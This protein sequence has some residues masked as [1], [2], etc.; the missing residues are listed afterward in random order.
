MKTILMALLVFAI[1]MSGCSSTS[2]PKEESARRDT[3]SAVALATSHVEKLGWNNEYVLTSP[4]KVKEFPTCWE[5]SFGRPQDRQADPAYGVV[6][7]DKET[8]K[9]TVIPQK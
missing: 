9:A 3:D 4:V 5:I 8:D 7:V 6:R 2:P 1:G